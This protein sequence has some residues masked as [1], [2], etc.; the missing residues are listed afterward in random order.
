MYTYTFENDNV[1]EIRNAWALAF[2]H[3]CIHSDLTHEDSDIIQ[4]DLDLIKENSDLLQQDIPDLSQQ[5]HHNCPTNHHYE[6][7]RSCAQPKNTHLLM[8]ICIC[9]KLFVCLSFFVNVWD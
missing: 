7:A 3:Y 6:A 4:E 9:H 5:H 2:A 1:L 8:Y